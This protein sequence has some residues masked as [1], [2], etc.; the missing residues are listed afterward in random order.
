MKVP[1]AFYVLLESSPVP[2]HKCPCPCHGG[3]WFYK[4]QLDLFWPHTLWEQPTHPKA[5]RALGAS[6]L[7]FNHGEELS[8]GIRGTVPSSEQRDGFVALGVHVLSSCHIVQGGVGGVKASDL[9]VGEGAV[10]AAGHGREA[11]R[12]QLA[13]R[14]MQGGVA[15]GTQGVQAE[16]VIFHLLPNVPWKR[17][18]PA[19]SSKSPGPL[20]PGLKGFIHCLRVGPRWCKGQQV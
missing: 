10:A 2:Q 14:E 3:K 9:Q 11:R 13:V 15:E 18:N 8:P 17:W 20:G 5:G 1:S 16:A 19:H 4:S 6:R 12:A 7:D